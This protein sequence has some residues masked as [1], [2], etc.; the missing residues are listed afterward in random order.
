[1]VKM[2]NQVNLFKSFG[3]STLHF[4]VKPISRKAL[5]DETNEEKYTIFSDI[6]DSEKEDEVIEQDMEKNLKLA[7]REVRKRL[8]KTFINLDLTYP[9]VD[10]FTSLSFSPNGRY[11][12]SG[13]DNNF[14][15]G[16]LIWDVLK[17]EIIGEYESKV[18]IYS[19]SFLENEREMIG[20]Y[21]DSFQFWQV[22][23]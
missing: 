10:T 5:F 9:M 22:T 15:Y 6:S 18:K 4:Q 1:M 14:S 7:K 21:N 8:E 13:F 11:L 3:T 12:V 20:G 19:P 2:P 23:D 16:L 17:R